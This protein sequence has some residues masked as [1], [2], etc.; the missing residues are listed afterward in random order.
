MVNKS[1]IRGGQ[2]P[3]TDSASPRVFPAPHEGASNLQPVLRHASV[4]SAQTEEEDVFV[5][6][7]TTEGPRAPAVKAG[8]VTH[9]SR[10]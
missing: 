10:E 3:R 8:R 4:V 6:N 1:L 2:R 7:D 9:A 5:F